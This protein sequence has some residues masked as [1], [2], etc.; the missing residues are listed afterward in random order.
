MSVTVMP[1][2]ARLQLRLNTGLDE[3]MNPVFRTRSYSSVKPLADNGELFELAQE[4]GGLQVHT[5]DAVRR[6]DE[7]QLSEA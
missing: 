5:L 2:S 6:V 7:V 3:N 1:I 4:L